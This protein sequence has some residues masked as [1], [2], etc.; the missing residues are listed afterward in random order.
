MIGEILKGFELAVGKPSGLMTT[1]IL[2]ER[3]TL[4]SVPQ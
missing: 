2:N 3:R 1:G 4:D